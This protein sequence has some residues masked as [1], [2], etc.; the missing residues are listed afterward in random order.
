MFFGLLVDVMMVDC[1]VFLCLRNAPSG[2]SEVLVIQTQSLKCPSLST[3]SR[4][5][6]FSY[7]LQSVAEAT[8]VE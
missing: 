6:I 2:S 8:S 4:N 5:L 7:Y 3:Q 1:R